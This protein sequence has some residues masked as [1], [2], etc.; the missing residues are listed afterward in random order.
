[1]RKLFSEEITNNGKDIGNDSD[2][3]PRCDTSIS[4]DAQQGSSGAGPAAPQL[5]GRL[6]AAPA[7]MQLTG[8]QCHW[9]IGAVDSDEFHFCAEP[10]EPA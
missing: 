6:G 3:E 7:V 10:A 1:M 4:S 9:P 2:V 8:F 5:E